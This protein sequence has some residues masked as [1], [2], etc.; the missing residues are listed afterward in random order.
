MPGWVLWPQYPCPPLLSSPWEAWLEEIL[1]G[2][3]RD[4][5]VSA[6]GEIPPESLPRKGQLS[7]C[8]LVPR[9]SWERLRQILD[10]P[11]SRTWLW[12]TKGFGGFREGP[13]KGG[14]RGVRPVQAS[15]ANWGAGRSAWWFLLGWAWYQSDSSWKMV[16]CVGTERTRMTGRD[17][18]G[19][20]TG[21]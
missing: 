1:R 8:L 19:G 14:F 20:G 21:Q 15:G 12:L 11:T 18:A 13:F 17:S 6:E 16:G 3:Q 5:S 2:A 7:P 10:P 9:G 4:H